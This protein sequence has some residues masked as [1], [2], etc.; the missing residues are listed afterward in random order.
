MKNYLRI[1]QNVL[2]NGINKDDRTKTGVRSLFG[3][4][5]RFDLNKGFPLLSTKRIYIKGVLA[6]LLWFISGET[7]LEHLHKNNCHIWDEWA[8]EKGDLGPIYGQQWRNWQGAQ[9]KYDQLAILMENLVKNP[10]SRRHIL[11][12]W[13]LDDL[14]DESLSPQENVENKKMA[15]APCHLLAQF[16]V[17]N[18]RLSCQ[19]YA[20]SQ[21]FFLGTPFNIASYAFLTHM[22]AHQLGLE[23]AE[24]IW[25]GGDV[26][27]YNN[28]ISQVK[29]QLGRTP[30][31]LLPT[32]TFNRKPDNLFSYKVD[33]FIINNY[34]PEPAIKADIAI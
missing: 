13:N 14:P 33:D 11:N 16:Y 22:I 2:D 25:I 6:E 20:R 10:N 30:K 5:M 3:E 7:N 28:H 1:L 24:L 23:V 21:D 31:A 9:D 32:L 18:N 29:K 34:S 12:A 15:L 17:I 26:H 27:L 19:M 8:D 4:K